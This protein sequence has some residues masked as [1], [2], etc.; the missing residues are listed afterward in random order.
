MTIVCKSRVI[1]KCQ[2]ALVNNNKPCATVN[3]WV[4]GKSALGDAVA[5][6]HQDMH[7]RVC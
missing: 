1:L 5:N 7:V 2:L 6:Q 3:Q 4:W